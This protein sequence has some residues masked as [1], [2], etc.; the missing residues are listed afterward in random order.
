M[1]DN[2][3]RLFFAIIS[4]TVANRSPSPAPLTRLSPPLMEGREW[5]C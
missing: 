5:P 3:S 4:R 2:L 1:I